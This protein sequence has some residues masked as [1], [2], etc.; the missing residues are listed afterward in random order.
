MT[1]VKVTVDKE[2]TQVDKSLDFIVSLVIYLCGTWLVVVALIYWTLFMYKES[3][4]LFLEVQ[5][6]EMSCEQPVKP[7]REQQSQPAVRS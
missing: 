6:L 4:K 5:Q 3:K 7:K 2:K 1:E